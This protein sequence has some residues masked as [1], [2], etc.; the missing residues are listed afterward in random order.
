MSFVNQNPFNLEASEVVFPTAERPL[1]ALGRVKGNSLDIASHKAIIRSDRDGSNP[2]VIGVVGSDY[3]RLP[4]KPLFEN[5]EASILRNVEPA[6]LQGAK[7][8]TSLSFDGAWVQR[9]YILPAFAEALETS[10]GFK[11]DIGFRLIGWNAL[12]GSS[13]A[14]CV[15]G[16]IDFYCTN[17]MVMGSLVDLVRRKHTKN[18][19]ADH[20]NGM[21]EGGLDILTTEIEGLRKLAITKLSADQAVTVLERH[22]SETRARKLMDRVEEEA[23]VRGWNVFALH[24]ALTFYSSHN[25]DQFKVRETGNDNVAKT[26]HNRE[27]EVAKVMPDVYR[28]AA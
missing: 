26:L 27:A 23:A 12:D 24:S 18:L 22:F 20:F 6:L 28:L 17:G 4:H 3:K 16:L 2:R 8:N 13:S 25:S 7:V 14:G 21:I 15:C 10:E 11:T 9:E 5:M 1:A 19:N